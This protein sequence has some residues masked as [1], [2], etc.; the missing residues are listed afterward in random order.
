MNGHRPHDTSDQAQEILRLHG[1]GQLLAAVPYLLGFHP[2]LDSVVVVGLQSDHVVLLTRID[3][4]GPG[5]LDRPEDQTAFWS[6]FA[7]P[8]HTSGADQLAVLGY[9]DPVWNTGKV[10][11]RLTRLQTQRRKIQERLADTDDQLQQ[12][13]AVLE[14]QLD[15]MSHPDEL[16]RRLNDHG[17]RLLNQVVF[18]RLLIDRP[19]TRPPS[20]SPDTTTAKPSATS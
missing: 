16:Y 1:A 20:R 10:R 3:L 17:R 2:D 12:G 18:D 19:P 11:T 5:D 13:A 15:L 9:T 14:A 4:P 8:L 6:L 7:R